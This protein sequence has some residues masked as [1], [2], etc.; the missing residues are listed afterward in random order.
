MITFEQA[1]AA[2]KATSYELGK[3]WVDCEEQA[4]CLP[5]L[6]KWAIQSPEYTG[7]RS[8]GMRLR[9]HRD[10]GKT[11]AMKCIRG[12]LNRLHNNRGESFSIRICQ[13]MTT[14]YNMK[15]DEVL[16]GMAAGFAVMYDD[17]GEEREGNFMGKQCNVMAEV[18]GKRYRAMQEQPMLTLC[19]TNIPNREADAAKYGERIATRMEEMFDTIVWKGPKEGFRKNTAPLMWV[20]PGSPQEQELRRAQDERRQ[21]EYDAFRAAENAKHEERKRRE[22]EQEEAAVKAQV[23]AAMRNIE[24]VGMDTLLMM[25]RMMPAGPVKQAYR[26]EVERR[27][28]APMAEVNAFLSTPAV[29]DEPAMRVE[30]V[31]EPEEVT[32]AAELV[33]PMDT[34]T[35]VPTAKE[36]AA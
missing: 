29:P 31:R 23:A 36:N 25:A 16:A 14:E 9:G 32:N 10:S 17:L 1:L 7:R 15:G 8:A 24:T 19:T 4:E 35:D 18:F 13:D 20:W 33:A 27:T 11:H 22:A 3:P 21:L 30:H 28:K 2:F 5:R 26:A 6:I 12:M 34:P